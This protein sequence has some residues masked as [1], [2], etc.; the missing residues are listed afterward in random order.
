WGYGSRIAFAALTCPGRRDRIA[1]R[2]ATRVV[3]P[4]GYPL[5]DRTARVMDL[6]WVARERKYFGNR[7][8]QG[9]STDGPRAMEAG[10]EGALA[11]AGPV[12]VETFGL[13]IVEIILKAPLGVH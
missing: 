13:E 5:W 12:A 7:T 11:H 8:G 10:F 4:R 6:I 9:E 2:N 1:P 3:I